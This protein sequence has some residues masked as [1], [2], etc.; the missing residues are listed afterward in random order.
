M[1]ESTAPLPDYLREEILL[2]PESREF[3]AFDLSKL[4]S[5][6]FDPIQGSKVCILIDFDEPADLIKDFAFLQQD[7]LPK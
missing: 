5:T 2:N 6:V 7:M 3:P 1:S 4:L